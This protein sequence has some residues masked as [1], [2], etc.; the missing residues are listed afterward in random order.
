MELRRGARVQNNLELAAANESIVMLALEN[1]V[2]PRRSGLIFTHNVGFQ[3]WEQIGQ[4]LLAIGNSTAWWVADWLVYGEETFYDRYR[5]AIQAT[6]LSYQTLRNYV[7]VARQFELPRRHDKLSF[8]H[9]AEVAALDRPEQDYWLRK[10]EEQ[11]WPRSR[12]R[13]EV[14]L[15]L[16]ERN[17]EEIALGAP[18]DAGSEDYTESRNQDENNGDDIRQLVLLLTTWQFSEFSEAARLSQQNL[19]EWA[20]HALQAAAKDRSKA[21]RQNGRCH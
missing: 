7:W 20:V 10:A 8:G 21:T 12:L 6:S 15:S 11:K 3:I 4:Q 19:E 14:R 13:K 9:H 18:G 16:R 17:L 2:V 5:E 1:S